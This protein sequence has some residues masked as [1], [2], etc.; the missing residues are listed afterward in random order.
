M[1]Y[2]CKYNF[3]F[4]KTMKTAGTSIE[5][6]LA[7]LIEQDAVVTAIDPEVAGHSPRNEGRFFNH[8]PA[9]VVRSELGAEVWGRVFSFCVERDPW[10]KVVSLYCMRKAEG[11]EHARD[12][13]TFLASG[14]LPLNY[15]LYTEPSDPISIIVTRVL[16]Y[17]TLQQDLKDVAPR[18]GVPFSGS[19][20]ERCKSGYRE[21]RTSSRRT[22]SS[23]QAE[24]IGRLFAHEIRL[25]GYR[26]ENDPFAGN[27]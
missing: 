4:I 24:L 8:V 3:V 6:C 16:K 19:L 18:L 15:P 21:P 10:E 26:W 12:M 14:D 20:T 25:H 11:K 27:G 23:S 22:L 13:D 2:S 9:H 1:L 7:R 17:E 5:V